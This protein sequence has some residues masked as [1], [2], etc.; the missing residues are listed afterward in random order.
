LILLGFPHDQRR[1]TYPHFVV[2]EL[3]LVF[4]LYQLDCLFGR[5]PL[6]LRDPCLFRGFTLL[7]LFL[8]PLPL[9]LQAKEGAVTV[10]AIIP[11]RQQ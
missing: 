2:L 11:Q 5:Q 8:F 7:A 1:S 10:S 6:Q 4:F 9:Q 3:E